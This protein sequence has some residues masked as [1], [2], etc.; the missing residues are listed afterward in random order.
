MPDSRRATHAGSAGAT[1]A[2]RRKPRPTRPKQMPR[3]QTASRQLFAAP[4]QPACRWRTRPQR[5]RADQQHSPA[6]ICSERARKPPP[7]SGADGA[8]ARASRRPRR[9]YRYA[10]RA[11][12]AAVCA[13]PFPQNT[14]RYPG[15][16]PNAVKLV[17]NEPVSTFSLDV[18]TASY[19]NVRRYLNQNVLPPVDAVRV[20]EMVNYFDYAYMMPRDRDAPFAPSVGGLSLAVESRHADPS[21]RDQGLRHPA[22]RAAEGESRVPD[23]HV[24]LDEQPRQAAAG[25][26]LVPD[27]GRAAEARGSRVDRGLCGLGGHGARA[28]ARMG[29]GSHP[30]LARPVAGRRLDRGRRRHPSGLRSREAEFRPERR[31]PRDPGDRRRFQCRHHRSQRARGLCRARTD[32]RRVPERARLRRRELQRPL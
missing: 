14:E 13:Y 22:Q 1:T 27:A 32:E 2:A 12:G 11:R 18:D 30:R 31:E 3:A 23:R 24:G 25:E 20:E 6:R 8:T 28:D 21:C 4:L 10:A 29:Q 7:G 26:A 9:S 16:R 5:L 15:A 17:A 19:A